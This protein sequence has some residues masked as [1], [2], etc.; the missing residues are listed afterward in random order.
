MFSTF[1][2]RRPR[3]AIVLAAILMISGALCAL[4]LPIKQY[5]NIAPPQIMVI[6]SYPGADAQT[7]ATTVGTPL[8]EAV[9]G[10]EKMIYMSSSSINNGIYALTI[11]FENGTDPDMALIKVQNRIHGT[12][13]RLPQIVNTMGINISASTSTMI[14]FIALTS[15]KGTRDELFLTNYAT[16]NV[17]NRFKRIPGMGNI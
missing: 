17:S 14:G 1:F 8:E 7:I 13:S 9:N 2:I 15:P 5:P 4:R 6:A 12:T 16:S 3:F 10:V 11:T